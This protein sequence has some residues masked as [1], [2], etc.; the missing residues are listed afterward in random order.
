MSTARALTASLSVLAFAL[1]GALAATSSDSGEVALKA[2]IHRNWKLRLPAEITKEIGTGI[3]LAASLGKRFGAGLDGT[4]LKL[5]VDADGTLETVVEGEEGFV[6]LRNGDRRYGVRLAASPRWTFAPGS[7][8]VGEVLGTRVQIID[9]NLN[10]RFDDYGSDAMIIGRGKSA[11]Y[12][13][14]VA[15]VNGEL[16]EFNVAADGSKLSFSPYEGKSGELAL[17]M[18]LGCKVLSLVLRSRD[19]LVSTAINRSEASVTLPAGEYFLHSGSLALAGN[20]VKV[21]QGRS[22]SVTVEEGKPAKLS[23]GGEVRAEFAYQRQGRQFGF[24]P[25]KIWYFGKAGEEYY[26]LEPLGKSPR[27]ALADPK[28]GREIAEAFFPGSC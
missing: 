15:S 19:G 1:T 22:P 8:M 16:Y 28:S 21:K 7:A 12:L 20:R 24:A 9:Q 27:I 10:G 18:A 17:D 2:K 3:D 11:S 13:S 26:D 23:L 25:D 6:V 5:D 14:K 4:S